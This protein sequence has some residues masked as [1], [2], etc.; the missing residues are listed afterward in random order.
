MQKGKKNFSPKG[1]QRS[2]LA[3]DFTEVT[4]SSIG[5]RT[6]PG[7]AVTLIDFGA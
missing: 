2:R 7:R 5:H 3:V 1:E 6:A 4:S